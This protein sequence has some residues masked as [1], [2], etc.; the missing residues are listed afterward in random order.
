MRA[1]TSLGKLI[2]SPLPLPPAWYAAPLRAILGVGF[3][4]HGYAKLSRGV[5]GFIAIL[6]A[7]GV[8][9][10]EALGWVT[11]AVEI[12]GGVL[13]LLGALIPAATIPMTVVLLTAMFTVHL[14]YGFSSIKLA[15]YDTS[16]AHFGPPGYEVDLLYIAGL[17]ALCI[18]GPGPLSV[19]GWLK[20]RLGRVGI[21]RGW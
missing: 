8:P 17:F 2:I 11:V 6:H 12:V 15:S 1:L 7:M 16:G 5:G 3:F 10:A 9:L 21:A 4:L 19:D 13:I 18:A 20:A 14:P